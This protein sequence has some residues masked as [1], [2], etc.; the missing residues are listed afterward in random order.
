MNRATQK[1]FNLAKKV[2]ENAYAPYSQFKVGA[3]VLTSN[4][5]TYVGCNVENV[6]YTLSTHAEMNAIDSAVAAG[7]R[8]IKAI[9]IVIDTPEPVFPC[10]LCRQKIIEFSN[11][12]EVTAAT[13]NGKLVS[14]N[15][16]DLYPKA[17]TP[18]DLGKR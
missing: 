16:R 14:A 13:L 17:F 10:A 6:S 5:K 3:A 18:K 1:L 2:R 4:G 7:D 12:I 15:I 9:C 8:K 11:D